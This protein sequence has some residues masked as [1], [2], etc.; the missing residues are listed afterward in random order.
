MGVWMK[1]VGMEQERANIHENAP[2]MSLGL[3]VLESCENRLR[4]P[5]KCL[6]AQ[7]NCWKSEKSCLSRWK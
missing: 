4:V 1:K 6:L 2:M 5:Q 3:G 7:K